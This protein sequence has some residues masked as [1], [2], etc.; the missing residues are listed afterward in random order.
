MSKTIIVRGDAIRTL[1][2]EGY[3]FE[4]NG[5]VRIF[6]EKTGKVLEWVREGGLTESEVREMNGLYRK[7]FPNGAAA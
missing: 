4:A 5:F 6:D 2:D 1:T 3:D 7:H